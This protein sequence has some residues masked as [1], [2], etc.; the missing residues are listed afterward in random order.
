MNIFER[1]VKE[2]TGLYPLRA[3]QITTLC[4]NLGS[5]CNLRCTHCYAD[6]SPERTEEMPLS[7]INKI[8]NVLGRHSEITTL[9]IGGG[10]P[11]LN[12][13]FR[14]FVK[15]ASGMG[16]KVFYA[17]NAAVY[18]EPGMEDLPEFLAENRIVIY[19]SLPWH[20]EEG[21]DRQRGRGTYRKVITALQKLNA[22]GYGR[23]GTSLELNIQFN[24]A[25][26]SLPPDQQALEKLFRE[27]LQEAHGITFNR[28]YTL[29]NMPIGRLRR[30][31]SENEL[32]AYLEVLEERF[33]PGTVEN[34]ICRV[35]VT[36]DER[37]YDCDFQRIL[38]LP[39]Q[40]AGRGGAGNGGS[41]GI[42]DFDYELLSNRE[43]VTTPL[44][45]VCTAG[46]GL[47][48]SESLM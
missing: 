22:L 11:E 8:L 40:P 12:P 15:T 28:L 3:R 13:H 38:N 23:Q 25:G 1:K 42:D 33:N 48:C 2:T 43:I 19:V 35:S 21:V 34:L 20:S 9:D 29:N 44:C 17:S 41:A 6:A 36:C 7:T 39:V 27:K 18:L 37:I 45:L 16:K 46:G 5:R 47:G 24:P 10:A 26:T 32:R 14:Y 30:S 31:I 4:V